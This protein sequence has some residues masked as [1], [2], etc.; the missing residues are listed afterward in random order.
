MPR[1]YFGEK[2]TGELLRRLHESRDKLAAGGLQREKVY[3]DV[4]TAL[5]PGRPDG[6]KY[7]SQ[8]IAS[9]LSHVC[10]SGLEKF[11]QQG[12]GCIPWRPSWGEDPFSK[13]RNTVCNTTSDEL[14]SSPTSVARE[15]LKTSN[16]AKSVQVQSCGK[17]SKKKRRRRNSSVVDTLLK[18]SRHSKTRSQGSTLRAPSAPAFQVVK[19]ELDVLRDEGISHMMSTIDNVI[20][21][22]A[23]SFIEMRALTELLEPDFIYIEKR[24]P[25]YTKLAKAAFNIGDGDRLTF[26]LPVRISDL[27]FCRALIACAVLEWVF[28][29]DFPEVVSQTYP[30]M[31]D[32]ILQLC[33]C[34]ITHRI[35]TLALHNSSYFA[36]GQKTL[37]TVHSMV[38]HAIVHDP[39]F[40][41]EEI[42]PKTSE[43]ALQM[44]KIL[45]PLV[46]HD[47][48]AGT[49][50]PATANCPPKAWED[51]HRVFRESLRFKAKLSLDQG[52]YR[53]F[54]P[55]PGA[56]FEVVR[57]THFQP[58]VGQQS[59]VLAG[60]MPGIE[61]ILDSEGQE[62]TLGAG[63]KGK[64]IIR[65]LSKA[66]VVVKS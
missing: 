18:E 7:T 63:A 64:P 10:E 40:E 17:G 59:T 44:A 57:M 25:D 54:W 9:K 12:V 58:D 66:R 34:S 43:L 35:D 26:N 50:H 4:A 51:L 27:D 13:S 1:C 53:F 2:N 6:P 48:N 39:T 32:A 61:R 16:R 60:L 21:D 3:N 5:P 45:Q 56:E 23:V 22:A 38:S 62:N 41:E 52:Q 8:Q 24:Y 11:Y 33:K 20:K 47:E 37:D 49:W 14:S 29:T 30:R 36:G 15:P 19:P 46:T 31:D 55:V 28:R 65:I 42:S